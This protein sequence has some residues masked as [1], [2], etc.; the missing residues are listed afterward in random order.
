MGWERDLSGSRGF[1]GPRKITPYNNLWFYTH[2][3][4]EHGRSRRN[5]DSGKLS[6]W[7]LYIRKG[8]CISMCMNVTMYVYECIVG[9]NF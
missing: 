2:G 8:M 3:P 6:V 9:E 4:H 7:I 1:R 5:E